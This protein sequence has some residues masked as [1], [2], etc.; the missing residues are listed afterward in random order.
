MN[1]R[2]RRSWSMH[3]QEWQRHERQLDTL[4]KWEEHRPVDLSP[5]GEQLAVDAARYLGFWT[6]ANA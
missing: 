4:A 2:E 5:E 6:E 1:A 3:W